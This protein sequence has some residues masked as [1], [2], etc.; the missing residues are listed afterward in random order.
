M[1]I[2]YSHDVITPEE[3]IKFLSF[4]RQS[5]PIIT[6]V[7]KAKE[8]A[9]KA[10]ELKLEVSDDELQGFCDNFRKVCNLYTVDET[11]DFLKNA[12]LSE[13]D[14][15]GFCEMSLLTSAL[16]NHLA[17]EEK[18]E[19]YFVNRRAEL[20]LA[21]I[22][23]ILVKDE[24]LANE[25]VLQVTE[26]EEDFHALAR[27]HSLDEKTKYAGGYIGLVTRDMLWPDIS[28][29]VFNADEGDLLGPF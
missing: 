11:L 8:V 28:A 18:I 1:E 29:K 7:I 15:E 27:L 22:S 19:E 12:G 9:K 20:D 10:K 23:S 21:R 16:K 5:V 3:V 6:E 17:T 4:T 14:F 13:D 24:G 26:D 2:V 25:I